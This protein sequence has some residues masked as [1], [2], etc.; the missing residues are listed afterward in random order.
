[1]GMKGFA[2]Y[3][4]EER[5]WGNFER[6]TLNEPSTVKI[7]TVEPNQS[8]SLQQHERR[9][10]EWKILKGSGTVIVGEKHTDVKPGDEFFVARATQHRVE[11]GPQGLQFLEVALGDFDEQ[12]IV[13]FE[14]KYGRT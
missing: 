13:R 3:K 8:L 7:I 12:D 14:D 2:N 10:E 9:D 11:A 1:M 6:F 5:P 4:K